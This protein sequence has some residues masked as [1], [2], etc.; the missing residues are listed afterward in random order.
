[1]EKYNNLGDDYLLHLTCISKLKDVDKDVI[2]ERDNHNNSKSWW[3]E[4]GF[5]C[6]HYLE[7]VCFVLCG[8]CH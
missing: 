8:M 4:G 6:F 7:N 2:H 3:D 5:K 1:M